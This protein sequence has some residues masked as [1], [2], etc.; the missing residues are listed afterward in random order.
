MLHNKKVR[1]ETIEKSIKLEDDQM[2]DSPSL[3]KD[4]L[5]DEEDNELSENESVG[6]QPD[7]VCL[8]ENSYE[9]CFLIPINVHFLFNPFNRKKIINCLAKNWE[10]NWKSL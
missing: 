8:K 1:T 4:D 10:R 5:L 7:E 6:T 2:A 3:N 9:C